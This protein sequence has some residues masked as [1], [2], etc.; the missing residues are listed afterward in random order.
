MTLKSPVVTALVFDHFLMMETI[1]PMRSN[2]KP[3]PKV[4]KIVGVAMYSF[5]LRSN[6]IDLFTL[7]HVSNFCLISG[8]TRDD[9]NKDI[10]VTNQ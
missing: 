8:M 9:I 6:A 3:F 7:I 10:C 5:N 1:N 4:G 2:Q